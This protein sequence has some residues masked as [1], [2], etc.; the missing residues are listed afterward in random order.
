MAS[1]KN[2]TLLVN[3]VFMPLHTV[4]C[5]ESLN[6]KAQLNPSELIHK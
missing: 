3:H 6:T 4:N 2:V 5:S 1:S